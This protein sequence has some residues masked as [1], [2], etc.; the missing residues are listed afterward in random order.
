MKVNTNGY[1]VKRVHNI[2]LIVVIALVCLICTQVVLSDGLNESRIP[3]IAGASI[4]VLMIINYI[5]PINYKIKGLLFALIPL[6]IIFALICTDNFTINKHYMLFVTIAMVT[7]YFRKELILIYGVIFNAGFITCYIVAPKQLLSVDANFKNFIT[8]ITL[9]N[10]ILLMLYFLTKWG[11]EQVE[12]AIAKELETKNLLEKLEATFKTIAEGTDTLENN[13]TTFHQEMKGVNASSE[14]IVNSVQQMSM[15]IQDEAASVYKIDESMT[16]SLN[17]V[18]QTIEIS[19]NIVKKSDDM[20]SKVENSWNQVNHVSKHMITVNNAIKNTANTVTE[21]KTS[22]GEINTLLNSIKDIAG[23][24]N[25]LALNASI[26]SARA[27][28]GGKGFAIVAEE[29]RKLSEKSKDIVENINNVTVNIF[30]RSEIASKMSAEG[31]K[32]AMEGMG[33]IDEVASYFDDIKVSYQENNKELSENMEKISV[34]AQNF[35]EIQEQITNVASISEENSA[36]TEEILSI[37]EDEN[38]KISYINSSMKEIQEISKRLKDM[39]NN[40]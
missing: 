30:S 36:S 6:I 25:L 26:E 22:L 19:K 28:E 33:I 29:I 40:L 15:A 27:G 38:T 24:T 18:N 8:I 23:Q 39:V 16:F 37:I 20:G 21:L 11:N 1:N 3:L 32:A 12:K 34:A 7:L 13:I 10:G 17:A 4:I 31:E 5:V 9:L 14:G 2:N 35:V